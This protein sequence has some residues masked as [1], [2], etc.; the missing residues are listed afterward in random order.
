[1]TSIFGHPGKSFVKEIKLFEPNNFK[2]ILP[3]KPIVLDN[4]A[5]KNKKL[6]HTRVSLNQ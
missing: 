6:N 5:E 1:M 4:H 2:E 3:P